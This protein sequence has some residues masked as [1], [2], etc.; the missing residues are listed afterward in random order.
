[1]TNKNIKNT[2]ETKDFDYHWNNFV[3]QISKVFRLTQE[4][5]ETFANSIT[6]KIIA[7]IPFAAG[8]KDAERTA[9]AHLS[10]SMVEKKGFQEYCAHLPS[11][12]ENLLNR[13]AFISTFEGGNEL[14]IEHGMYMLAL[15]MIEG[16]KH[17][18]KKDIKYGVYNPIANGKW[19][20]NEKKKEIL[21]ILKKT[22]CA[23]LD[24][25]FYQPLFIPT[26]W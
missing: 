24:S 7:K 22:S 18:A 8:C 21:D 9:I 2:V 13:L 1:M 19:N 5:Q 17:S 4:E 15:I 12:D 16:Y 23:E 14:I 25:L 3:N 20:Y 10:L 6:A 11:D 26:G